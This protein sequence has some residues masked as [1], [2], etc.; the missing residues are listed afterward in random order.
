MK[1][2]YLITVLRT[3]K[4][5]GLFPIM[6]DWQAFV[7]MHF[8]YT[9]FESGLLEALSIPSSRNDLIQKLN[10]KRPEI[11]EALLDVGLSVKELAYK[12]GTYSIKGKRSKAVGGN[13][14]DILAAMI[15]ANITYYSSAYRN[16][17]DRRG[18]TL[19]P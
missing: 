12:D 13:K 17:A 6:R 3:V 8:I 14:G 1:F 19:G 7:R 10:V 2:K 4:M 9:A 5:P 15:Q 11:L 16:A 18:S